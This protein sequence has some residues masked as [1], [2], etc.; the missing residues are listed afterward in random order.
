MQKQKSA[1]KPEYGYAWPWR[2]DVG[3]PDLV[4]R[5]QGEYGPWLR[6]SDGASTNAP[7]IITIR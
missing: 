6:V 2:E 1:V 4:V 3:V 5:V 7:V